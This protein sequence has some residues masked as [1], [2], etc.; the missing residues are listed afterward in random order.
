M[1]TSITDSL[2]KIKRFGSIEQ[3]LT[4]QKINK[5]ISSM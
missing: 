5:M 1:N 3:G 4:W 2:N